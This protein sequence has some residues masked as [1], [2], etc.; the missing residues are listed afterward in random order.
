MNVLN[1]VLMSV[2]IS[3]LRNVF[4]SIGEI[5]KSSTSR[6]LIVLESHPTT[7]TG[8]ISHVR[9]AFKWKHLQIATALGNLE[10]PLLLLRRN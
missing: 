9:Q 8:S 6:R 5:F 4:T 10:I 2:L 3:L 1:S 7:F